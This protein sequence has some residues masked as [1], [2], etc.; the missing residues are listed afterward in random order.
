ML[1]YFVNFLSKHTYDHYSLTAGIETGFSYINNQGLIV[2]IPL[3]ANYSFNK[4]NNIE[5]FIS[6]GATG[7]IAKSVIN[8]ILVFNMGGGAKISDRFLLSAMYE[9]DPVLS[10]NRTNSYI[11]DVLSNY[12]INIRFGIR[13]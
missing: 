6:F 10:A 3:T 13:L 8:S 5:P 11:K 12:I 1:G 2:R 7:N 9:I 4:Q